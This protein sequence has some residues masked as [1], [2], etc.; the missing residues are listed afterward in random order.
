MLVPDRPEKRA[1]VVVRD[2]GGETMLYDPDGDR[3]IRLN[4]TARRIW[5]LC[6]GRHTVPAIVAALQAEFSTDP[7]VDLHAD[8]SEAV[9][10]FAAAALLVNSGA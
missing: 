4:R 10:R 6:D 8:V 2:L 9:N 7:G 1:S 5:D 3:V